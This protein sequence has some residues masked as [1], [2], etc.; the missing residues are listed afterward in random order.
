MTRTGYKLS[1]PTQRYSPILTT[2]IHQRRRPPL[3]GPDRT[4]TS[5]RT[6]HTL[7]LRCT[8]LNISSFPLTL[9]SLN[10]LHT[11]PRLPQTYPQPRNSHLPPATHHAFHPLS[12]PRPPRHPKHPR[13]LLPS[14]RHQ[15]LGPPPQRL[16]PRRDSRL[17]VQPGP[18]RQRGSREGDTRTV[19]QV[20][21]AFS[22]PSSFPS[23]SYLCISMTCSYRYKTIMK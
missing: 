20:A 3:R 13:P 16:P 12:P 21:Y 6:Y 22:I 9:P 8:S 14:P 17:P 5:L 1:H 23:L 7:L 4:P 10:P 2:P 11:P 19:R 15:I 18:A